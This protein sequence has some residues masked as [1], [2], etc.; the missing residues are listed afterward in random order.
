MFGTQIGFY[1]IVPL[2]LGRGR[3]SIAP[4][5]AALAAAA[6][7]APAG[8]AA[9]QHAPK[10]TLRTINSVV[11]EETSSTAE[12]PVT[13][14]L[15]LR[16]TTQNKSS[17]SFDLD[18]ILAAAAEAAAATK[19]GAD[20]DMAIFSKVVSLQAGGS[21]ATSFGLAPGE[22]KGEKHVLARGK[23]RTLAESKAAAAASEADDLDLGVFSK[24][25]SLQAGGTQAM[26]F[27]LAPGERKGDR[28]SARRRFFSGTSVRAL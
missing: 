15:V 23:A 7:P 28:L 2:L 12:P 8:T 26:S 27:G 3:P 10:S 17:K 24:V 13:V 1:D 22:R 18:A 14:E 4:T 16:P 25:V 21:Q 19:A 6:A 11:S 5:A 20:L 9:V